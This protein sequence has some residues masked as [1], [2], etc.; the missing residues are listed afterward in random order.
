[1]DN[2]ATNTTS[3]GNPPFLWKAEPTQR[4]TFGIILLCLST[5]IICVWD[6]IHFNIPIRR[7]TATRRFFHQVFWMI[8]AL[9]APEL[10]LFM[11]I[12]ERVSARTLLKKVLRVHPHLAEP[13]IRDRYIPGRAKSTDVSAQCPYVIQ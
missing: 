4:G 2:P 3:P 6:T 9:L 13:G 8:V 11:A 1:M 7:Y 10:L 5:L 12:N